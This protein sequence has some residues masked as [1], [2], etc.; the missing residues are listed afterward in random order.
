MKLLKSWNS[1]KDRKHP[2]GRLTHRKYK[3]SIYYYCQYAFLAFLLI[4]G[5]CEEKIPTIQNPGGFYSI[6]TLTIPADSITF[7]QAVANPSIGQSDMLYI[8]NDENVYAYSLLKL[9]EV[10]LFLPDSVDEFTSLK[11]ILRSG[12]QYRLDE[13]STD[14]IKISVFQIMNDGVNP[15][16]EDS[17]HVNNF[18]IQDY[19]DAG[20]LS[21]LTEF[22]YSDSDTVNID[23]GIA[24]INMVTD[25]YDDTNQDYTLVFMQS[26]T[27]IAAIQTFYSLETSR[28]PY[29][30]VNYSINDDS[31]TQTR[32]VLP[33]EDLSIIKFKKSID[34][35]TLFNINSGRASFSVLKFNFE[36]LFTDKNEYIAKADLRLN[37]DPV[38]TQQ[39]GE[40][41]YLYVNLADSSILDADGNL[42][43]GYDPV[44]QTYDFYHAVQ[45][46]ADSVVVNI[47]SLLQ[48][49][50]SD[51][52]SN[53]GIVLYTVPTFSNISTLSLYN[54]SDQN[55]AG[56][57]PT[58]RILTMK[59][60]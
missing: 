13:S 25:W 43:P 26:D 20:K 53:Y 11:L 24:G 55:P 42:D 2:H 28:Y 58:L 12:H 3:S 35:S 29:L 44:G 54:A 60:Q 50:V 40:M 17:N 49:V 31:T 39:Y 5:A 21:F 51:Y 36:N 9:D 27:N 19:L 16:S 47:K 34:S 6:D 52:I 57:R 37:V 33:T 10:N 46:S 23:L 7:A 18:N 22:T 32:S 56:F 4:I 15:W 38:Q 45:A 30:D 1:Y 14:S 41:F 8:G 48:G 59:E